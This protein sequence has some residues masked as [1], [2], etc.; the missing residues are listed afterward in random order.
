MRCGVPGG[1]CLRGAGCRRSE[2]GGGALVGRR[3]RGRAAG[4]RE[5]RSRRGSALDRERAPPS[6]GDSPVSRGTRDDGRSLCG[7]RPRAGAGAV[8]G[9][10][11]AGGASF[12]SWRPA[13]G[14][15]ANAAPA[16]ASTS[17][18]AVIKPTRRRRSGTARATGRRRIRPSLGVRSCRRCAASGPKTPCCGAAGTGAAP[19]TGAEAEAGAKMLRRGRTTASA[20]LLSFGSSMASAHKEACATNLAPNQRRLW[21]TAWRRTRT[22]HT[23]RVGRPCVRLRAVPERPAG[24]E[25]SLAAWVARSRARA[26]AGADRLVRL[27]LTIPC[28]ARPRSGWSVAACSLRARR[29]AAGGVGGGQT[30][31]R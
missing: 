9:A 4:R 21:K 11:C 31:R 29:R 27:G 12:V 1:A 16:T 13:V 8:R 30:R 23:S 24:R 5:V 14:M 18:A 22:G 26:R 6:S 20:M 10:G 17:A 25:P 15:T 28:W 7:A 3:R 2:A 19:D